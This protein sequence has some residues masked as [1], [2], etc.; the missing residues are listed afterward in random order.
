MSAPIRITLGVPNDSQPI[1]VVVS[2]NKQRKSINVT[3]P[4]AAGKVPE[5]DGSYSVTP[6]EQ[7]QTLQTNGF[8]MKD[9]V[10]VDA[11]PSDYVGSG[12]PRKTSENLT[13]S[14]NT[15]TAPAGYYEGNASASVPNA[16]W[17]DAS[18]IGVVPEITV[19]AN[20][21]I[22]ANC[23]GWTSIHPLT[24]SGYADADTAANI[25]ETGVKTHQLPTIGATTY[26]PTTVAQEISAQQYLTGKQTIEAIPSQY[27]D[28]SGALAWMGVDAELVQTFTLADVK[29]KDC[30]W[31]GWAPSTTAKDIQATR[32]AGTFTATD[33]K[34]YDY[35]IIW[36]TTIPIVYTTGSTNLAKPLF[37]AALQVQEIVRRPSTY[38]NILAKNN[39]STV[40]VSASVSNSFL[41]YYNATLDNLAYTWNASYGFYC[42]VTANTL[43]SATAANPTVTLK[44]PKVTARCSTTYLSTANA[45][46][47]D[48]DK[49]IIH[50]KAKVY[51]I[52]KAGLIQGIYNDI[53]RLVN[54][55]DSQL[56]G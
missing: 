32:T 43:N 40:N 37:L 30:A 13:A 42:T 27:K 44:S 31:H 25:Q 49:T 21:L 16:T 20:G 55:V 12:V 5:Y 35:I 53:E 38:P 54:E 15:V 18:T 4:V 45:A 9:D 28:M 50:Q 29:F 24:S 7:E 33:E 14:G 41:R 2:S 48:E 8:L 34:D 10:S 46:L 6:T 19:D 36:E 11:I 3:A 17:K 39:N 52:R 1:P 22:T 51:R 56:G 26:T 23:A 47:I